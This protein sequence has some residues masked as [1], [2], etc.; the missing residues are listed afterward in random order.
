MYQELR[1]N[2]RKTTHPGH[3]PPIARGVLRGY[4]K[5]NSQATSRFN[6]P[7]HRSFASNYRSIQNFCPRRDAFVRRSSRRDMR[8]ERSV[9][10]ANVATFVG[11][12]LLSARS[13]SGSRHNRAWACANTAQA[14]HK[15]QQ[16]NQRM[17]TQSI[18]IGSRQVIGSGFALERR[19]GFAHQRLDYLAILW[20]A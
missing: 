12:H 1:K 8:G 15:A 20:W 5:Q 4:L 10:R 14:V 7:S 6:T 13:V 19:V 16:R 2:R 9:A 3:S 11:E 18:R 17:Q